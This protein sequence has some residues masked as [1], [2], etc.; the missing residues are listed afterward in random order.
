MS[1]KVVLIG[2]DAA[3]LDVLRPL[4][5]RG[6]LP[7]IAQL[8]R[9]GASGVLH[10]TVPPV[11]APAWASFLTG[12]HPGKH[13]LYSFVVERGQA[14]GIQAESGGP[15]NTQLAT[16][17]DIHGAKLWDVVAA[18]GVRP[19]VA[20][21]P[22]T[23][24]TPAFDGAIVTG[25]LT[26]ES[27]AVQ[28]TH[29][30]ELAAE[31]DAA[32]PGYKIDID[33]SMMDAKDTLF[34]GMTAMTEKRRDLFIHLLQTQDYGLFVGAFT[35]TDRAQHAFWRKH[36]E[37]VDQHFHDVDTHIGRILEVIDREKTIVMLMSDHGFQSAQ[38]KLYVNRFLEEAGL[39]ATHRGEDDAYDRRRPDFFDD[40]QGGRSEADKRAASKSDGALG[41]MLK[42]VGVGG[43]T[44]M[45]WSRTRAFTWSLDTAGIGINLKSRYA[46]GIV[47]DADYET[48]RNEVI[49][50]LSALELP[51]GGAAFRTVRRREDV[52]TGPRAHL[53]PDIVT[54]PSDA[55]DLGIQLDAKSVFRRHKHPE[56]HHSPRGFVSITGPGCK[57]GVTIEGNIV[58]CLPTML[59]ALGLAV[60]EGLD[61]RVLVSAFDDDREVRTTV[62]MDTGSDDPG[63]ETG[64][65]T[66]TGTNTDAG[67]GFSDE[68][69]EA[70]RR[71]LEGLGYL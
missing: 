6:E 24:P 40:F 25:M 47:E 18:Q 70:L 55:M 26:P 53:A 33:R 1:R 39:L 32:V 59:H 17:N 62:A 31:I 46:H 45:D 58:D 38:W 43:R 2:L 68:E 10:S 61:G 21:I 16:L 22:V 50:Q 29:P 15:G 56:G 37:H 48:V 4:I 54:E 9:A 64:T 14:D 11:S 28:W 65:N 19:V 42:K 49:A 51:D 12:C 36:R 63:A 23:W 34:A 52:Y 30:P 13:G 44:V 57:Q 8:M 5:E 35:N 3:D 69:E 41:K 67:T 20:N 7:H 60:P 66:G 71:S 27:R